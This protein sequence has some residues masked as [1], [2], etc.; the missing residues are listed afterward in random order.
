[1][2]G[3]ATICSSD[4]D[5]CFKLTC[6]TYASGKGSFGCF[7]NGKKGD[8]NLFI[9]ALN[10]NDTIFKY[11]NDQ[12]DDKT[13]T[14]IIT[15]FA[16]KTIGFKIFYTKKAYYEEYAN[17][18]TLNK[19]V[20]NCIEKYTT[21]TKINDVFGFIIT[22]TNK[23]IKFTYNGTKDNDIIDNYIIYVIMY[24]ICEGDSTA[25]KGPFDPNKF[26]ADITPLMSALHKNGF[27][28]MDLKPANI[29]YC[30]EC[31]DK[32]SPVSP[33]PQLSDIIRAF[34]TGGVE[35]NYCYKVSDFSIVNL[36]TFTSY[37]YTDKYLLPQLLF[38]DK[39][40]QYNPIFNSYLPSNNTNIFNDI[41]KNTFG[42]RY[43]INYNDPEDIKV[44]KA[45]D[46]YRQEIINSKK[47][48]IFEKNDLDNMDLLKISYKLKKSDEYAIACSL[49]ELYYNQMTDEDIKNLFNENIRNSINDKYKIF[50]KT[51]RN[52]IQHY[53]YSN[54]LPSAINDY[55]EKLLEPELY[56]EN[57]QSSCQDTL[58]YKSGGKNPIIKT[59]EKIQI[60]GR[61][62]TLY[63]G[64]RKKQYVKMK[65]LYVSVSS[66]KKAEKETAKEKKAKEKAKAKDKNKKPKSST[67]K[68]P[69]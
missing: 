64:A 16:S 14:S 12:V 38:N 5:K 50:I 46:K 20:P 23:S 30:K 2:S 15:E 65:G 49:I 32:S 25:Y 26:M 27:A 22:S 34:K 7:I 48:I 56:F 8:I 6:D 40:D 43:N 11:D 58:S 13:K 9:D 67:K 60:A 28:H 1:M 42:Y 31:G 59:K 24:K 55:I 18:K 68:Q 33:T 47:F 66:L 3:T 41:K 4:T 17:L 35:Q 51:L 39:Y 54:E 57:K 52:N 44:K 53:S 19:A 61:N 29:L 45:Y 63:L 21:L 10:S 69:K 36:N 62:R 37:T